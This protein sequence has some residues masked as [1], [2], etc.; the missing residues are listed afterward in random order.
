M[1][2]PCLWATKRDYYGLMKTRKVLSDLIGKNTLK[3]N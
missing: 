3:A 1:R 2:E